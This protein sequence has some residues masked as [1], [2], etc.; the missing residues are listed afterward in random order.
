M[1]LPED[2]IHLE[3]LRYNTKELG[4]MFVHDEVYNE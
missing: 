4:T 3:F 2:N 1:K